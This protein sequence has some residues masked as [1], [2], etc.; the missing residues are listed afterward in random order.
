MYGFSHIV[1]WLEKRLYASIRR[2]LLAQNWVLVL[3][4]QNAGDSGEYVCELE[5]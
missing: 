3:L 4:G 5:I 1:M 2:F